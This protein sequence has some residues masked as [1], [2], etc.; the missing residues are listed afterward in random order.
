MLGL[1]SGEM[2]TPTGWMSF[3]LSFVQANANLNRML[4]D[5]S[6]KF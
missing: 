4:F 6:R 3:D 1:G 2:S 5:R